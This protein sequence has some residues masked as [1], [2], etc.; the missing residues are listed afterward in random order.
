MKKITTIYALGL[1]VLGS[2][3]KKYLDINT[4][5]NQAT[6]ATPE[7]ILPQAITGTAANLN[8]YNSYGAQTVGY[9]ANA[10]GYGGFGTSITY[11]YSSSDFSGLW[12]STYDNLEDYQTIINYTKSSLP[13]YSYYNA[14]A[15]IMRAY[16]FALLVDTYNDVP[17]VDALKGETALT[18]TYT[19]AK[20]I[21]KSLGQ[22]LDSAIL[23][24]NA[25]A[26]G[27]GVKGMGSN[28]VLFKGDMTKWKQFA[29]TIKLRL[30]VR[31][32]GKVTFA[33]TTF[34][35]AGFLTSDAMVNPG[36]TRDNGKQNPA[37]NSWAFSYTGGD[38]NK[39]WMPNTFVY[40]FYNG[41]KLTD[42]KRGAAVYYQYPTT[43]TNRLGYENTSVVA[44]PSGSFWYSGSNRSGTSAGGAIGVLKGPEAGYPIMLA[45]E[46]YFLQA[47]A[48]VRGLTTGSATAKSLFNAGILA[49][50]TYLYQKPDGTIA[51]T[52]NVST[53]FATY[54]SDNSTSY[55]VNFDLATSTALQTEAIITQKYIAL[56]YISGHEAWNEYRRTHYP[57]IISTAG[58]T[59]TQTF[60][61][62]VS[63]STRP[64]KLPTRV[65]YP[66]TEGSYNST[67]M[68]KGVTPFTSLIFWAL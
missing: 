53:Y 57:A 52:D 6:S 16:N 59:A 21:Y 5:P 67:N 12:S 17:Y 26:T 50:F 1:L 7:V 60:A 23:T 31:A 10:G 63:E 27:I 2:S 19:D 68:P 56:N 8:G 41:T 46:S 42:T 22:E 61:S 33:S 37:W 25:G 15:R 29:N 62:T 58:A 65:L 40:S 34:D 66:S 32:T 36:F 38:A 39:A 43:P 3:C 44:S 18:P 20:T 48:V 9:S 11:N 64:D 24:I 4:N 30:M 47:E 45:A 28:D 54:Q 55:L 13:A 14:A 51:T 49:S 35:A